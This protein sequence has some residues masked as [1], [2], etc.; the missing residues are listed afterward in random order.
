M[1]A[2]MKVLGAVAPPLASE[3]AYRIWKDL[4]QPEAV[5][6]RDR[7][8]HESAVRGELEVG[9]E[10]VVTYTWGDGPRVILLVHGWRSRASRFAALVDALA[11]PDRTIVAFDAPGNGDSTGTATTILDY[12]DAVRQLATRYGGFD[13]IVAHSL[14]V[15]ASFLA[16]REG[17]PAAHLVSIAGMYDADEVVRGFSYQVGISG[18]A[19][20]GLRRRIERRTFPTIENPWRLFV[21]EI[22]PVQTRVPLLLVHDADDAVVPVAQ[23][24][25]IADAHTGPV[26][27]LVTDGL[28][29]S[30]ILRDPAV[31]GTIADF[32]RRDSL[33]GQAPP[34]HQHRHQEPRREVEPE[35]APPAA[36]RRLGGLV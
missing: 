10:R 30:R 21:S 7:R 2:V 11:S 27:T 26:A 18:R 8:V 6:E 23:L 4:G 35:E 13:T 3:V 14:G 1:V 22:D 9:G 20:N 5:H 31:I 29:H 33:H 15:I 16:V 17:V 36:I 32:V 25:I 12:A 34:D 28:G 19:L 24:D